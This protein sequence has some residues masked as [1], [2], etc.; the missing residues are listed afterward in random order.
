MKTAKY[1]IYNILMIT[2]I[3]KILPLTFVYDCTVVFFSNQDPYQ[4]RL[5][6]LSYHHVTSM[7][8][9]EK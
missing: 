9:Q 7:N 6:S 1:Y 3:I 8:P 2:I 5:V 4:H